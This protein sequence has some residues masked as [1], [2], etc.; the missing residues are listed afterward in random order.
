MNLSLARSS[1]SIT[2]AFLAR[3]VASPSSQL[4]REGGRTTVQLMGLPATALPADIRRM[5]ERQGIKGGF[6]VQLEYRRYHPAGR[7]SIH[8]D[9]A[10]GAREACTKLNGAE[11]STHRVTAFTRLPD[12][13]DRW[14]QG[15]GPDG[16]NK[17]RGKTV[18][19][20]GLS[21]AYI[22]CEAY[23]CVTRGSIS[24]E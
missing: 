16:G 13:G 19:L 1:C 9:S 14:S 24:A 11:I 23:R 2:H 3:G 22:P 8:L 10:E 6:E 12:P 15:F 17:E 20:Q 7:A 5:A 4:A 18:V 21:P